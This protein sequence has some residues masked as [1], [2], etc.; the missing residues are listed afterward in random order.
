[1][2]I[3]DTLAAILEKVD[4]LERKLAAPTAAA[5]LLAR[6]QLAAALGVSVKTIARLERDGLPGIGRGRLRRFRLADAERFLRER[7][8]SSGDLGARAD[9]LLARRGRR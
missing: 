1:M 5:E 6:R 4:R 7:D 3:E 8:T 9:E 2:S